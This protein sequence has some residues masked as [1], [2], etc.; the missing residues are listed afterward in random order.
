MPFLHP[1]VED[2]HCHGDRDPL[3]VVSIVDIGTNTLIFAKPR[4]TCLL[5][6]KTRLFDGFNGFCL[7]A[8][9]VLSLI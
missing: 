7:Y 1:Q 6:E 3:I 2:M 4:E 8:H 9:D 5:T